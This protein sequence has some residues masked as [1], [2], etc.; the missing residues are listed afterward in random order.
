ML[1]SLLAF[2]HFPRYPRAKWDL[3]VLIP[4]WVGLYTFWDPVGLSN[5]LSCKAGSF[6]YCCL[7][8]QRVFNR[9]L[10]ALFPH[11]RAL[12]LRGLFHSAFVLPGLSGRESGTTR[13]TSHYLAR[14][15]SYSL[16]TPLHNPPPH[17]VHQPPSCPPW[18]SSHLLAASPLSPAVHLC[19]SYRS[20]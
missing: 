14:P 20:G 18:S 6:S 17:W 3:L 15:A 7:N 19:P 2:S 1:H 4:M 10:E 5:K 13:S 9:W 8:P 16:P 12:G 11:A